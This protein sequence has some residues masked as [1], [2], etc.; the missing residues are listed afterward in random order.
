MFVP[1]ELKLVTEANNAFEPAL[2]TEFIRF[3]IALI[4]GSVLLFIPSAIPLINEMI[5]LIPAC[6]I[7]PA[8]DATTL[9]N[10]FMTVMAIVAIGSMFSFI[11]LRTL[12]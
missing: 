6:T 4:I 2:T 10:L 9:I 8:I 1:M 7:D 5:K 3:S 12:L 11:P